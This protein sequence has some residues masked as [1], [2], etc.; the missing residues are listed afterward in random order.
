MRRAMFAALVCLVS[1]AVMTAPAAAATTAVA[2]VH[3]TDTDFNNATTLQ[4]VTVEG[5]GNSAYVALDLTD[6][7]STASFSS[8]GG[9]ATTWTAPS[10]QTITVEMWGPG[11]GDGGTYFGTGGNGGTG[12]YAKVNYAIEDGDVLDVY[13]GGAG[14]DGA[15]SGSTGGGA[16]GA[17]YVSG[18][19]GGDASC[20]GAGGGGG[21]GASA[22]LNNSDTV[23]GSAGGGGGGG[24][25]GS[26]SSECAD[27]GGGGGGARGGTGGSGG[28]DS[29]D[30]QD[31]AGSGAGGNGGSAGTGGGST[32]Q[33][34]GNNGDNGGTV[35]NLGTAVTTSSGGGNSGDGQVK[36]TYGNPVARNGT[37]VGDSHD[38]DKA[39][40]G[41]TNLTLT[42]ATAYVTW[43]QS[44]DGGNS[45]SDVASATYTTSGNKTQSFSGDGQWRVKIIF[46]PDNE[47][48]VARLHDEGVKFQSAAPVIDE[49]TMSPNNGD[50]LTDRETTFS[51]DISDGDFGTSQGDSVQADLYIDG[52]KAGSDT[53]SS[54]GT[55][56]VTATVSNGGSHTYHWEAGDAWG[57]SDT[58]T[59]HTITVPSNLSIYNE[60]NSTQLVDNATVELRFYFEDQPTKIVSKNTSD[61]TIDMSG[62][63]ADRPFVVVAQADGYYSRRIFV[64]SLYETES[65]YLLPENETAVNPSFKLEDYTGKYPSD[66]TVLLVQRALDNGTAVDWRTVEGDLFGGTGQF[67][68]TLEYNIRHR[69]V[70]LNSE[71]GDRRVL[72]SFTPVN[73]GEY[74]IVVQSDD[75]VT[76]SETPASV[77]IDPATRTLREADSASVGVTI[78]E[79]GAAVDSWSVTITYQKGGTSTT[80]YT[81]SGTG[82]ATLSPSFNLTG[83]AGGDVTVQVQ[84]TA[85]GETGT[86]SAVF[87]VRK[88]YT[89]QYSLLNVLGSVGTLLPAQHADGVTS[90]IAVFVAIFGVAAVAATFPASTET[91]GLVGVGIIAAFSVIG[92]VGYNV[93]FVAGIGLLALAG[94]RRGV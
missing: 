35:V 89:N 8:P 18:G 24:G 15:G 47:N 71:T 14:S 78:R 60:S 38:V 12:G 92:W 9:T 49:G 72:G 10:D 62:L 41:F 82:E 2:S 73:D 76:I 20:T 45:W 79:R 53:L 6:G 74:T 67:P 43:Q 26:A 58:S 44:T 90:L 69:L 65:V 42:S 21:G 54:N 83:R 48:S 27:G 81:N 5:S 94:I 19:A 77:T 1:V 59:T 33:A 70:L 63:P 64:E 34:D 88:Q 7:T 68:T 40:S 50:T 17:G 25:A 85:G 57:N 29:Q 87:G 86:K 51:V 75:E 80:L 16:G 3:T 84:T 13:V 37:Y 22:V 4:N 52:S 91:L 46:E 56:S 30:G 93:V 32:S 36:I 66:E 28:D 61:G 39:T 55:A 23:I 31:A 11:G